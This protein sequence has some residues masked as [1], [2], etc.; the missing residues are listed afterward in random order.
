MKFYDRENELSLLAET[1]AYSE[2]S[3][4]MTVIVGRRRVGKNKPGKKGM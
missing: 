2:Y 1:R 4:K 3:A